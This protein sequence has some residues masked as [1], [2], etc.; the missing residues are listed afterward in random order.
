MIE[1]L[2]AMVV[3]A[4]LTSMAIRGFGLASSQVSAEQ[5]LNVYVGMVAR[6]RAQ[7]IETGNT[8]MVI[9]NAEGDSVMIFANGQLR[10][11]VRFGEEMGIDIQTSSNITQLCMSPRG[12]ADTDCTSFS[13]AIEMSFVQGSKSTTIEILPLGQLRW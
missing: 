5:A 10:E 9:T 4:I 11:N 6:A 3:G 13:S 12:Y 2:M 8:T 7:A 1:L